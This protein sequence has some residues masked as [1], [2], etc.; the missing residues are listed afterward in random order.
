MFNSLGLNHPKF[1]SWRRVFAT[2]FALV[3][4]LGNISFPI[5][6]LMGVVR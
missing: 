1:N 4:T 3:I 6:V 5:F 2:V